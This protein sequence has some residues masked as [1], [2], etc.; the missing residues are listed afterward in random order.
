MD[1][2]KFILLE[3]KKFYCKIKKRVQKVMQC[4]NE[5]RFNNSL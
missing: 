2:Q 3:P 5:H 1:E 4:D